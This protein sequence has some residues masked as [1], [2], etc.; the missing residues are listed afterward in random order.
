MAYAY[1]SKRTRGAGR[2]RARRRTMRPRARRAG[3]RRSGRR[4]GART[5]RLVITGSGVRIAKRGRTY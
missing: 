1:R 2:Y 4:S 5:V 3:A